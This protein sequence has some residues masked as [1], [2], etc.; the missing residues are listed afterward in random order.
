L[1]A[2]PDEEE[3]AGVRILETRVIRVHAHERIVKPGTQR[4]DTSRWSPLLYVFR[5]YFGTG[6]R[7]ASNFRVEK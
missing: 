2:L 1:S 6:A 3:P 4:I 5:D 7:L